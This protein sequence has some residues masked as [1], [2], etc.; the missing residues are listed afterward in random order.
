MLLA[1]AGCSAPASGQSGTS[2]TAAATSSSAPTTAPMQSE[3]DQEQ[4][5]PTAGDSASQPS[6][7]AESGTDS[8][9][10]AGSR[11]AGAT[12]DGTDQGGADSGRAPAT[13]DD[14][15]GTLADAKQSDAAASADDASAASTSA[16]RSAAKSQTAKKRINCKKKKCIAITFD[17]GPGPY[18]EKLLRELKDAEV[19]ATFFVV[20]SAAKK[21]PGVVRKIAQQGHEVGNH[22]WSHPYLPGLSAKK[23]AQQIDSTTRAITAAGVEA[24][25]L[26]R[27]PYGAFNKTTSSIARK[28]AM[29]LAIWNVDTQDWRNRNAKATTKRALKGAKR[30]AIILMHDIHPTTVKAAPTIIKK[31]KKRGYTLVTVSEL[32]GSQ[33][34]GTAYYHQPGTRLW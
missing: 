8:P 4:G 7:A 26:L 14:D 2:H 15:D 3:S 6:S 34:S 27:P 33:K 16:S 18:T 13:T 31:L 9:Q 24:P 12:D 10:D 21:R 17:D 19:R 20:G 25:T 23:Q 22:S 5:S 32:L 11:S 29:S 1:A 30:G 28:R